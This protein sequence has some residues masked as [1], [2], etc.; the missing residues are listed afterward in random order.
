MSVHPSAPLAALTLP[1]QVI[2]EGAIEYLG[3]MVVSGTIEGDV[4]CQSLVVTERG[5]ING[6]V[7]AGTVT[8]LGEINGE[9][10]ANTLFLKTA[11][12]VTG[13]IYHN[14]L[15]LEDGCYFEGKSRRMILPLELA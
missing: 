13:D 10:Y 3:P 6:S 9:I 15:V 2:I 12:S 14:Q 11:C 5:V 7:R 8:V 4:V 1:R